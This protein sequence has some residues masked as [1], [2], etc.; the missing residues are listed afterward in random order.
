[1]IDENTTLSDN[2]DVDDVKPELRGYLSKWTNY[3]HGWQDRFIVLKD[4]TLSYYKSEV[5]SNLGCRGALCLKKVKVKVESGYGTSSDS[6]S[7]G[8]GLRRHDSVTSLQSTGSHGRTSR[9]LAEKIAELETFND[10][11][12][13]QALQLQQYFDTCASKFPQISDEEAIDA[14]KLAEIAHDKSLVDE[15]RATSAS[16]RATC[17]ATVVNIQHCVE[18]LKRRE[19]QA[20]KAEELYAALKTQLNEARLASKP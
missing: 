13:K 1:M 15:V 12:G 19:K 7:N 6:S 16:F 17:S 2:S 4:S 11:L 8:G 3:I 9:R 18:L 10:L 20:R 14:L 5:E